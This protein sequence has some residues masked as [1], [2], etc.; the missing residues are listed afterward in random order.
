MCFKNNKLKQSK[1]KTRKKQKLSKINKMI[2]IVIRKISLST[3]M[4][5]LSQITILK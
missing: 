4:M 2:L 5:S 3:L 1:M